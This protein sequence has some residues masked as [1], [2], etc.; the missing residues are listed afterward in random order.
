MTFPELA[1]VKYEFEADWRMFR[2]AYQVLTSIPDRWDRGTLI[3]ILY[4]P[5]QD[6]D[7]VIAQHVVVPRRPDSTY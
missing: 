4:S 2:D 1:R 3:H 5:E 7:S 6:Y